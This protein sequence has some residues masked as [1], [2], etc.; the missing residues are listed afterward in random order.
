MRRIAAKFAPRLLTNNQ[1]QRRV[2]ACLELRKQA[3][4]DATFTRISKIIWGDESWI[5]GYD[6]ETKQQSSQWKSQ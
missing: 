4:K 6:R 3:N 1:K 5:Y 2:N